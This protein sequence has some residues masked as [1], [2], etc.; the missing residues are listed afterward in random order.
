MALTACHSD[1]KSSSLQRTA[2]L[3]FNILTDEA[4]PDAMRTAGALALQQDLLSSPSIISSV[5][6]DESAAYA[7]AAEK[8]ILVTVTRRNGML[9]GELDER[10][11]ASGKVGR[12]LTANAA[13]YT[14]LADKLAK[15]LDARAGTFSTS[16]DE[17]LR[18]YMRSFESNDRAKKTEALEQAIRTD[19][20]FGLAYLS[21]AGVANGQPGGAADVLARADAQSSG[22]TPIDR[23]RLQSLEKQLNRDP[24]A[25]QARAVQ[26]IVALA[27]N[28]V[29]SLAAFGADS[30]LAA[31]ADAGER[32]L[33]KAI[34]YAPGR[35]D[36]RTQL[37]LGL[38]SAGRFDAAIEVFRS[39]HGKSSTEPEI[40]VCLLLK[41][42]SAGADKMM[43]Q[44]FTDWRASLG[45]ALP[46]VRA[47]WVAVSQGLDAA[48]TSLNAQQFASPDLTS[49]AFSQRAIWS[50]AQGRV[51]EAR[52]LAASGARLAASPIAKAYAIAATAA[53][54]NS[55]DI[56]AKLQQAPMEPA[57]KQYVIASTSF[58]H[59]QYADAVADWA[60]VVKQSGDRDLRA[61]AMLAASLQDGGRGSESAQ[62]RVQPFA[63]NL[64]GSDPYAA[65]SFAEMRRHHT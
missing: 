37:G 42:D 38:L 55:P 23:A 62:I 25:D 48:I 24:L 27:P 56:R 51:E 50:V 4:S 58:L 32:S 59:R 57:L 14:G 19:P 6:D 18:V 53:A 8:T 34:G 11:L 41:G 46:L 43:T 65:I 9:H 61:R 39:L 31:D 17:A 13:S 5:V 20:H 35:D 33:R 40:A 44:Y 2:V 7:T 1:D 47:N 52:A 49:M 10:D 45:I 22:F 3:P 15:Q 30:F 28:D 54:S 36:L 60:E 16:S 12:V 29:E 63:P 21:L 64:S 26:S